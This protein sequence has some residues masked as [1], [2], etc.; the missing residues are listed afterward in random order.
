MI[1]DGGRV[2]DYLGT[3][4]HL[5]VDLRLRAEDD[6]SLLLTTHDQRFY[7]GLVGFRFPMRFSG[8]AVLRESWDQAAEVYGVHL[9]VSN[10]TFGF[11]F[12]YEGWFTCDFVPVTDAPLELKPFRHERRV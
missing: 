11:L 4:Q 10:S 1:F 2:V 5:A 3:H 8:T 6:G 7:E 12:G 9:E